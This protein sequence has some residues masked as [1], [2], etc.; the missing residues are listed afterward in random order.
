MIAGEKKNISFLP[1]QRYCLQM[2]PTSS[3][4]VEKKNFMRF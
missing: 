1:E 2:T 3:F 4:S